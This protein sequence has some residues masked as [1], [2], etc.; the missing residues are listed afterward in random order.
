M[1]NRSTF[2]GLDAHNDSS[3][4][5]LAVSR[6]SCLEYRSRSGPSASDGSSKEVPHGHRDRAEHQAD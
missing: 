6:G 5:L 2:V 4:M 1:A 3:D